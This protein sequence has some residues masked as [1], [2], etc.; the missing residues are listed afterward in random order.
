MSRSRSPSDTAFISQADRDSRKSNLKSRQQKRHRRL[1]LEVLEGRQL[2]TSDLWTQLATL[3]AARGGSETAINAVD[4][5]SYQLNDDAMRAAL[6]TAPLE[7]AGGTPVVIQLPTPGGGW[8]AFNVVN[9]PIMAPELAAQLPEITTY[10]GQGIDDPA[11]SVRLDFTPQGFHAQVLSASGSYY[12]DPYYHLDDSV[13]VSYFRTD[14]RPASENLPDLADRGDDLVLPPAAGRSGAAP[15][16]AQRSGTQLRTYRTAVAATGEYTAF[17]GG[18]AALGQAA[19]VTA[20][21]RV[22]GIYET[23]LSIRLQLVANNINLVYTNAA[24]DPYTNDDGVAMLGQNQTTVDA[25]IGATNYDLGH[26][27]STGGGGVAYLGVV[28]VNSWKAGGVTGSS[29]PTGD[30]F[31]VDYVAHEMGHQFG[32]NHTFNSSTGACGGGNRNASTAYE[33]GSGSTIQ[34]YSGI[35]G[36]DDLQFNSDPY[37]HSISFD[38]IISYVD[39][40]IPGSGDP[41]RHRQHRAHGQRRGRLHNPRPHAVRADRHRFRWQRRRVDVQLGRTRS[42]SV[43]H[44]GGGRTTV[45]APSSVS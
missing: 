31:W 11:A 39:T 12:V 7:F 18:T 17:H 44:G 34:A 26:V 20:I 43:D 27:F 29:S 36:A 45:P 1:L 15:T 9:S 24:T 28:G 38:E 2:L 42:G 3:P 32:G 30:G 14:A 22:S 5:T 19:I 16:A 4:F 33:P 25:L 23:E 21:N 13:Y 10:A 37:F 40:S 41:H 35:C 8:A 6:A